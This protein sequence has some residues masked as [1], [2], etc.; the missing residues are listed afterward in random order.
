MEL[1]AV[2]WQRLSGVLTLDGNVIII[3]AVVAARALR[4]CRSDGF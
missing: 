1:R 4:N 3:L 2:T